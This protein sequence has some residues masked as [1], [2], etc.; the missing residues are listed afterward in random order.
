MAARSVI[1][2][3]GSLEPRVL[4]SDS[5]LSLGCSPGSSD[6]LKE[7]EWALTDGDKK[8][9]VIVLN[10]DFYFD[11][12]FILIWI[13]SEI[14]FSNHFKYRK[15]NLQ[16][17]DSSISLNCITTRGMIME[18]TFSNLWHFQF[19]KMKLECLN[20]NI[21]QYSFQHDQ[22]R[23]RNIILNKSFEGMMPLKTYI[24]SLLDTYHRRG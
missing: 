7:Y 6:V 20:I 4:P 1:V 21:Y 12:K 2:P 10:W 23:N 16:A 8:I 13:N 24:M 22:N 15:Q 3:L 18:L 9:I 11:Y 5:D 19:F 17:L 14:C